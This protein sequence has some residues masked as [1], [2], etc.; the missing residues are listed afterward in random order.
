MDPTTVPNTIQNPLNP[1]FSDV[2]SIISTLSA[3]ILPAATLAFLA[4]LIYG[5]FTYLT[6][7][8]NPEKEALAKKIL[9]YAVIGFIIIVIAPVVVGIISALFGVQLIGT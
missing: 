5:G 4:M 8:G 6:A 3:F 1:L 7:A 9:T 2:G